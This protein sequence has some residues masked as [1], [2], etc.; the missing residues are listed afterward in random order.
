LG[1]LKMKKLFVITL[2]MMLFSA[3]S[4]SE[5]NS[6]Q[7]KGKTNSFGLQLTELS[8]TSS[9][10]VADTHGDATYN[11][12]NSVDASGYC[13]GFASAYYD[14]SG[15]AC[16]AETS[17]GPD[18]GGP[19]D[20]DYISVAVTGMGFASASNTCYVWAE[21][22]ISNSSTPSCCAQHQVVINGITYSCTS[23]VD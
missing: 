13:V 21:S 4:F 8:S 22:Y 9:D 19:I 6:T 10:Y 18:H 5:G 17:T 12:T 2:A 14:G 23:I 7:E 11:Y 20:A 3:L 1:D 16:W 15:V